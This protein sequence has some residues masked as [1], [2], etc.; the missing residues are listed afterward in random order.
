MTNPVG[1]DQL[2]GPHGT[3]QRIP[4]T[5]YTNK[6]AT[7]DA[8]IITAP[9]WHPL[10][11]QYML[12]LITLADTPGEAPAT[13]TRPGATHQIITLAMDPDHGPYTPDHVTQGRVAY[14]R[15]GN[16]GEQ[17]TAT[18]AEALDV[19]ALCARAVLDGILNPETSDAPT[20]IRATWASSIQQT[21]DHTRDPHHGTAN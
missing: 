18:D 16:I 12:A 14:L 6:P 5:H 11:T 20:R 1:P 8:Y 3:A 9:G 13:I 21:L 4:R 19:I 2:T 17:F 15:P 10:W 7:L